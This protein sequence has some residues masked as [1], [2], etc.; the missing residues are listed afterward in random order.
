MNQVAREGRTVVFVSHNMSALQSLCSR[1][2]WLSHGRMVDDGEA[3]QVVARYLQQNTVCDRRLVWN[4]PAT[5]PG[6]DKVRLHR[7]SIDARHRPGEPILTVRTPVDI[8]ISYWNLVPSARLNVSLFLYNTEDVCVFNTVS[9]SEPRPEGL[10]SHVCHI[11]G[12]FL[13]DG[14]YWVRVMIVRDTS[15]PVFSYQDAGSFELA[16]VEREGAWFG[17]WPGVVRPLLYWDS[18][19]AREPGGGSGGLERRAVYAQE[20]DRC[21]F[22]A[23]D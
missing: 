6:N 11:P 23:A 17:K 19:V 4:D 16:D 10:I 3:T 21:Y 18:A 8:D 5:A 2:I 9:E 13:N 7:V 14:G 22:S 15:V 12:N 20:P 1:A